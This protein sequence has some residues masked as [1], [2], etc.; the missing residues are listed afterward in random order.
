MSETED[1][2]LPDPREQ[3]SLP[4]TPPEDD[5]PDRMIVLPSWVPVTIG[6]LLVVIAG[7][8]VYTGLRQPGTPTVSPAGPGLEG[9]AGAGSGLLGAPGEPGAGGSLVQPG[10]NGVVPGEAAPSA[11]EGARVTIRGGPEGVI[12]SIRTSVRRGIMIDVEPG[13]AMLWVNDELIGQVASFSSEQQVYEFPAEGE[14][15]IRIAAPGHQEWEY[16]VTADESAELE[17]AIIEL[18]LA[19]M[20]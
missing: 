3:E 5:E 10:R 20:P 12:P 18:R 6:I 4:V 13:D 14:Y 11:D 17:V 9:G 19:P 7:F 16:V 1:P 15:I 2:S 8:A